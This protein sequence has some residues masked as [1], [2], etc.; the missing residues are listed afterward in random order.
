M[1]PRHD[2]RVKKAKREAKRA[3][4]AAENGSRMMARYE[5]LFSR[6]AGLAC[7]TMLMDE[8]E[9]GLDP[10]K[11]FTF[12][13]AVKL[14]RRHVQKGLGLPIPVMAR[15]EG[16]MTGDADLGQRED[17][18]W[19]VM[20]LLKVGVG[21]IRG[22]AERRF[23]WDLISTWDKSKTLTTAQFAWAERMLESARNAT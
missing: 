13:D 20:E 3:A 1:D 7:A 17:K 5:E 16:I 4:A 6:V 9:E 18:A 2:P 11:V 21:G 14:A 10:K 19:W 22:A 15:I 23:V 8:G 12:A